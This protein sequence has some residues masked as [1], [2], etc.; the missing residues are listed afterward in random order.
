MTVLYV[1]TF[2]KADGQVP[3]DFVLSGIGS[4]GGV[5]A[6]QRWHLSTS[7]AGDVIR[8]I[9]PAAKWNESNTKATVWWYTPATGP[10]NIIPQIH[11]RTSGDWSSEIDS[12]NSGYKVIFLNGNGVGLFKRIGG[13]TTQLGAFV[14]KTITTN[15]QYGFTIQAIGTG[16][17][18]VKARMWTGPVEP[19]TWDIQVTDSTS[20]INGPGQSQ[21]AMLSQD[22]TALTVD[23]DDIS[24][25]NTISPVS[26]SGPSIRLAVR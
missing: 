5:C 2:T 3:D 21:A 7:G 17:V 9:L 4:V 6:G 10:G 12:P 8:G 20:P 24:L 14:L 11:I 15:G 16:S 22:A 18:D 19:S 1:N 26:A 13:V 25:D 23:F